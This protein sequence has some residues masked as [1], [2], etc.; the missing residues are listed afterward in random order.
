MAAEGLVQA[1]PGSPQCLPQV[2]KMGAGTMYSRGGEGE[3][4]SL[5]KPSSPT[6]WERVTHS[7]G[8]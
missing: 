7:F 5:E 1:N 6:P 8:E 4:C 2:S 3:G